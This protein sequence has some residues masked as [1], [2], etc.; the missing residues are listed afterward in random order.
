MASQSHVQAADHLGDEMC[1]AFIK[2]EE[3]EAAA[4]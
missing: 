3:S 2:I 1:E 4:H